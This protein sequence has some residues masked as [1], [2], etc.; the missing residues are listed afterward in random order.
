LW[1]R[2]QGYHDQSTSK[3][4]QDKHPNRKIVD[5]RPHREQSV[6]VTKNKKG[7]MYV[8]APLNIPFNALFDREQNIPAE[9]DIVLSKERLQSIAENI[10]EDQ[11]IQ[12]GSPYPSRVVRLHYV[13]GITLRI[14]HGNWVYR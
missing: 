10:W 14:L 8:T 3:G 6:F 2:E 12:G 1:E 7:T 9:K 5:E 13:V 11:E 4:F